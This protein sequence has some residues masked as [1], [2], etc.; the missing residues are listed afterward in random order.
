MLG[1][2]SAYGGY[3]KSAVTMPKLHKQQVENWNRK[4][5]IL[6]WGVHWD[7]EWLAQMAIEYFL[8]WIINLIEV[9]CWPLSCLCN[10]VIWLKSFCKGY[11]AS[12]YSARK[13]LR[14]LL[15][16]HLCFHFL[17]TALA[18]FNHVSLL[19]GVISEY[20]TSEVCTAM[21]GPGNV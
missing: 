6:I 11:K 18:F 5:F 1:C 9:N 3:K 14:N 12:F 17:F 4:V 2:I 19:Y 13:M 21:T 8:T 20:C 10:I 16:I 7:S 15:L